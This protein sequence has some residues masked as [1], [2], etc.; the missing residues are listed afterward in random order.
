MTGGKT[1]NN[2]G[3]RTF[4]PRF[5][6]SRSPVTRD[7]LKDHGDR[8]RAS[9]TKE[10]VVCTGAYASAC[11]SI[12][13]EVHSSP[14]L[15]APRQ[16]LQTV[17]RGASS[18]RRGSRGPSRRGRRAGRRA[19]RRGQV[20]PREDHRRDLSA[21][22]RRHACRFERTGD[23]PLHGS[24]GRVGVRGIAT[25]LSRTSRSA[26]IWTSV[27]EPLPRQGRGPLSPSHR[28]RGDGAPP[29]SRFCAT[30]NVQSPERFASPSRRSPV[31]DNGSPSP[32]REPMSSALRQGGSSWTSYDGGSSKPS[33][34]QKQVLE[35]VV[36]LREQGLSVIVISH[37]PGRRRFPDRGS[38][39]R[40]PPPRPARGEPPN[41]GDDHG[42]GR[43][44]HHRRRSGQGEGRRMKRR[45][46]RRGR[47]P[48][49]NER[50][51]GELFGLLRKIRRWKRRGRSRSLRPRRRVGDLCLPRTRTFI[52]ARNLTNLVLQI[53]ATGTMSVGV[54]SSSRFSLGEIDLVGRRGERTRG[55]RDGRSQAWNAGR[56]AA[57]VRCLPRALAVGALIRCGPRRVD[58]TRFR[59][60]SFVVTLAGLLAFQ[61]ALSSGSSGGRRGPSTST[62]T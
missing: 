28:R 12:G 4:R 54:V 35:L 57:L 19:T 41:E 51:E 26:T 15:R 40:R 61:G 44:P 39:Q 7:N 43:R 23:P 59:V 32:W 55:E 56:G 2:A 8:R 33:L 49:G 20:D 21:G 46:P 45:R 52:S 29:R 27:V 30:L 6:S 22:R 5:S 42:R 16:R 60:P 50:G 14:R 3:G 48:R 9:W 62:T 47:S 37:N 11:K 1:V 17:R 13:L 53:A 10:Q 58:F 38:H 31:P 18:G 36:R 25:C 24:Q 34:K